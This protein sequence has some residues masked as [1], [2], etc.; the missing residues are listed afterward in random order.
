MK[1]IFIVCLFSFITQYAMEEKTGKE[2]ITQPLNMKMMLMKEEGSSSKRN[3][4]SDNEEFVYPSND[5]DCEEWEEDIYIEGSNFTSFDEAYATGYRAGLDEQRKN[6]NSSIIHILEDT[7]KLNDNVKRLQN[8][9]NQILG[10][11]SVQGFEDNC[12]YFIF[13]TGTAISVALSPTITALFLG[14]SSE[15]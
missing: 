13:L 8:Q 9:N 5:S 3:S 14:L 11:L 12:K 15:S 10:K 4:D 6:D 2:I 7:Q 1:K